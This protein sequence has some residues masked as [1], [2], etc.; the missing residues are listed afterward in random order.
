MRAIEPPSQP[1]VPSEPSFEPQASPPSRRGRPRATISRQRSLEAPRFLQKLTKRRF[2]WN[3]PCE[4][5]VSKTFAP[6]DQIGVQIWVADFH[7]WGLGIRPNSSESDS[8]PNPSESGTH[9][10]RDEMPI[11]TVQYR[12][13]IPCGAAGNPPKFARVRPSTE[14]VRMPNRHPRSTSI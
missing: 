8:L 14:S 7:I 5:V 12:K 2:R 13:K 1:Q 10:G 11:Q 4:R 3:G 9:F 6:T